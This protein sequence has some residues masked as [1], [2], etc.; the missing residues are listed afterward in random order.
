LSG[1]TSID[2]GYKANGGVL[3]ATG[4]GTVNSA[5]GDSTQRAVAVSLNEKFDKNTMMT[6]ARGDLAV[7]ASFTPA[8]SFK[9]VIVTAPGLTRGVYNFYTKGEVAGSQSLGLG[10]PAE[11]IYGVYVGGAYNIGET[12]KLVLDNINVD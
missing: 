7:V 9:N 3:V 4:N 11:E 10:N 5:K 2:A 6:L 1:G 8:R 12:G